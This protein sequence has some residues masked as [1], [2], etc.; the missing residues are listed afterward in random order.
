MK[1]TK[2]NKL[3]DSDFKVKEYVEAN[4]AAA[5]RTRWISII[6]VIATVL[7][8][9]G[10]YNSTWWSWARFRYT[11]VLDNEYLPGI[12]TSEDKPYA[13]VDAFFSEKDFPKPK[14]PRTGLPSLETFGC[15]IYKQ[16][17]T[18]PVS[19]YL[20]ERFNQKTRDL[21]KD[22]CPIEDEPGPFTQPLQKSL[23]LDLNIIL[24][25]KFLYDE[26]RFTG[27]LPE[28]ETGRYVHLRNEMQAAHRELNVKDLI[29]LNR[30]LLETEFK[31]FI[32]ESRDIIPADGDFNENIL[33]PEERLRLYRQGERVKAHNERVL[34]I[35]I[36]VFGISIDVNDLGV[37]GGFSLFIIVLMLRFSL[38]REI[39][40]LNISFREAFR[41]DKLRIFYHALAMRQVLTMP[42][43]QGEEKNILLS[44][45]AKLFCILP[46]VILSLGFAYDI[47]SIVN[48][49]V[50]ELKDVIT[51]LMVA[52]LMLVLVSYFSLRC[53]ERKIHIDKIWHDYSVIMDSGCTYE[54]LV[55]KNFSSDDK[56]RECAK[57][58]LQIDRTERFW[59]SM[60]LANTPGV[61]KRL[62]YGIVTIAFPFL[63]DDGL[64]RKTKWMKVFLR[65]TIFFA[66]LTLIG[67][68]YTRVPF[69]TI[70][71]AIKDFLSKLVDFLSSL[72]AI[73][74]EPRMVFM[75]LILCLISLLVFLILYGK[76]NLLKKERK[77]A[78][79]DEDRVKTDTNSEE[80]K[81]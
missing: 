80:K 78:G 23:L 56:L 50:F 18:T 11:S 12:N 70:F 26:K 54:Q 51:H 31:G 30:L 61:L 41:H 47:H 24:K 73:F 64:T 33:S 40:N 42:E 39:K 5:V 46:M 29:R 15:R 13:V 22:A 10:F 43:M 36:P 44:E 53:F 71:P 49:A 34:W 35:D 37:I 38:S 66:I 25:D 52:T 59:L 3:D 75:P 20:F 74:P 58:H 32:V 63:S 1:E 16:Q 48:L 55:D 79:N 21:L 57:Y 65:T 67:I 62:S 77:D 8:G 9:I 4:A 6:L 60:L 17:S 81:E 28:T 14:E 2:H 69:T 45:C 68:F 27:I 19:K 72:F 7:V 76:N